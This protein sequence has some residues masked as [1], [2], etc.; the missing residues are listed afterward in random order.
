[1]SSR[2]CNF[3]G[4]YSI[5]CYA[6]CLCVLGWLVSNGKCAFDAQ[7]YHSCVVRS[8]HTR[9]IP[10]AVKESRRTAWRRC[11]HSY[12][13]PEYSIRCYCFISH[14]ACP[15]FPRLSPEIIIYLR[16]DWFQMCNGRRAATAFWLLTHTIGHFPFEYFRSVPSSASTIMTK[17]NQIRCRHSPFTSKANSSSGNFLSNRICVWPKRFA[18][19]CAGHAL[20]SSLR[21]LIVAINGKGNSH[22]LHAPA[23]ELMCHK[24][25]FHRSH[26]SSEL[27]VCVNM[28]F[29]F[30]MGESPHNFVLRNNMVGNVLT[31]VPPTDECSAVQCLHQT[32]NALNNSL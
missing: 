6:M 31:K 29:S 26:H 3:G 11:S 18:W 7:I 15:S 24:L 12:C 27:C 16:N 25:C 32:T 2:I 28:T 8:R 22:R 30:R 14:P 17:E 13:S 1:M 10:W 9:A 4:E 20:V 21:K 23:S 19:Q 5:T